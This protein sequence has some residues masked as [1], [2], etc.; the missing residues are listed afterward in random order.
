[1]LENSS[2]QVS[3]HTNQGR[4]DTESLHPWPGDTNLI[5]AKK[6]KHLTLSLE[7]VELPI[8]VEA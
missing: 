3:F 2:K 4:V 1:M 7:G 8:P 5:G 6:N